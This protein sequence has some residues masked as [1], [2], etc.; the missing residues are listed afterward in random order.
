MYRYT[1]LYAT[2]LKTK[3]YMKFRQFQKFS[4]RSF[5]IAGIP[6]FNNAVPYALAFSDNFG[7]W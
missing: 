4:R 6:K 2:P 7:T 5:G 1:N 3:L